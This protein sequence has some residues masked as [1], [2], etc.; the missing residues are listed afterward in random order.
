MQGKRT[1]RVGHLIQMEISKLILRGVK[2]PRLGGLVTITHVDVS[3]DLKSARVFYSLLGT[4]DER[5]QTQAVLERAAGFFQKEIGAVLNTR[6]TPKLLFRYDDSYD[7][8]MAVDRALY[9]IEQEKKK[10]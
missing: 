6:Y 7:Q 10:S 5:K 4:E 9:Q 3:K 8:G 1:D 2:D